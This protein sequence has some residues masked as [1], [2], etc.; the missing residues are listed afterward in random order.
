MANLGR[1]WR[2]LAPIPAHMHLARLGTEIRR[3]IWPPM[4][5]LLVA[6]W[7]RRGRDHAANVKIE[8]IA[9]LGRALSTSARASG[10]SN[11]SQLVLAGQVVGT[12]PAINWALPQA[13]PL[14]VYEAHYL[15]WLEELVE[16]P[17]A[18]NIDLALSS[19]RGWFEAATRLKKAWEPYPRARRTLHTLRALARLSVVDDSVPALAELRSELLNISATAAYDLQWLLETHLDGN[20][21]LV[22]HLALAASEQAFGAR[23]GATTQLL[24]QFDR[25]W[26]EDGSH[27][28]Q[29]PMYHALLLEDLLTVAGLLKPDD[30][31]NQAVAERVGR[32]LAWLAAVRHPCGDLPAFGD[33]EPRVLER[34]PMTSAALNG[35]TPAKT[36]PALSAWVATTADHH[37]VV[38]TAP[39][40][41]N[42]QPG[43]AHADS[44]SLE[45]SYHGTPVLTDA[46]LPGYG[47]HPDRAWSRS[48]RA[49]STMA[50]ENTPAMELWAV[51]RLGR[52]G[53]VSVLD[54]GTLGP[55]R[56]LVACHNWP[57]GGHKHT[58]MVALHD[59]GTL[60]LVDRYDTTPVRDIVARTRLRLHHRVEAQRVQHGV[61]L[62]EPALEIHSTGDC[63]LEADVRFPQRGEAV[64]SSNVVIEMTQG[65]A[66][67]TCLTARKGQGIGQLRA[68]LEPTWLR[69]AG[70]EKIA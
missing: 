57:V 32:A 29:S 66:I 6:R 22:D 14:Q 7:R 45:Y 38:H 63:S 34:L 26:T 1:I 30:T 64:A 48:E 68:S 47:G 46:G 20:H 56:W 53:N 50:L 8:A 58:R 44:L 62:L 12:L 59:I 41:F 5:P 33:T 16:F 9:R 23:K 61:D 31:W 19:V 11:T 3:R 17:D 13:R 27:I 49:H 10:G 35:I 36:N 39:V 67:W 18:D 60:I 52:R 43:H 69:L 54:H 24:T 40:C 25:Q 2:T 65:T 42:R 37:V 55:W 15:G 4:L 21:L 70:K 51:F 28:E